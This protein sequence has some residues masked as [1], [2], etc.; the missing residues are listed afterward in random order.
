[1]GGFPS[2]HPFFV[3]IFPETSISGTLIFRKPP[4]EESTKNVGLMKV[5]LNKL[6]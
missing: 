6:G 3:G 1:M 4:F 2:Y 5:D